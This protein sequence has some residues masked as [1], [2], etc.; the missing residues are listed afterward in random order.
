MT[1]KSNIGSIIQVLSY[2]DVFS[3]PLTLSEIVEFS[4]I[5]HP[6]HQAIEEELNKLV[7]SGEVFKHEKFY[8]L[9]PNPEI[10]EK[11]IM[12]NKEAER[13]MN[14][15]HRKAQLIGRF[16]FVHAVMIS[17]SMSKGVMHQDGDI[18]FFIVTKPNRLWIART[19]LVFYKKVF[20]LN[21]RKYFCVNYFVDEEHLRIS[22]QNLFTATEIVTILPMVNS[23][24]YQRFMEVN[25]WTNE[26][27][28]N[29]APREVTHTAHLRKGMFGKVMEKLLNGQ[30]GE[31]LDARFM[32][33]KLKRWQRKS[34]HFEEAEFELA[35]KTN[36]RV[37]KHHPSN[38]QQKVLDQYNEKLKRFEHL[39]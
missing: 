28:P 15:A 2:Y 31:R 14:I 26:H 13:K 27:Y 12:S 1:L 34:G 24:V 25:A 11:R 10:G 6:S 4:G 16:P 5:P 22:E 36:K 21:S 3:H 8:S 23:E 7:A 19:L 30:L 18:D 20:L 39:I 35:M 32:K 33:I 9:Q 29:K 37:S 17:G 38:F